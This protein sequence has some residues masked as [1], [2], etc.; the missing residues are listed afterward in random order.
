[1]A[2]LDI[3]MTVWNCEPY[4]ADTLA[5][6]QRQTLSDFRLIVIDD[7]S[8]DQTGTIIR[9]A[10]ADDPRIEYHH[11]PNAGIVTALITVSASAQP[12][13]SAGMTATIFL[14]R[15]VLKKR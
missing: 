8:T 4:I 3:L 12:P 10:A 2:K 9:A 5:S 6:I 7:G 1:M 15:T 13:I 11:Q 14:I